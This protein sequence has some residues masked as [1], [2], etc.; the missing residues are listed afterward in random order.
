MERSRGAGELRSPEVDEGDAFVEGGGVNGKAE[1]QQPSTRSQHHQ[2]HAAF[3][4][5]LRM[6]PNVG[7]LPDIRLQK[8]RFPRTFHVKHRRGYK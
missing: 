8:R 1:S 4:Q 3:W 5:H 2:R 6:A 7:P